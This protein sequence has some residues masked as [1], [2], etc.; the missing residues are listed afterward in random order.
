[1]KDGRL[2]AHRDFRYS[3]STTSADHR[4]SAAGQV[5]V[6]VTDIFH[7]FDIRIDIDLLRRQSTAN[8]III[9]PVLLPGRF[10]YL[11]CA[12]TLQ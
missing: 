10:S 6:H 7:H 11:R 9:I 8:C 12:E 3:N 2:A 1:M 4:S 5:A